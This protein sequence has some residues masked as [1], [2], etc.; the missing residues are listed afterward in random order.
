MRRWQGWLIGLAVLVMA[1]GL[2]VGHNR[3]LPEIPLSL[4]TTLPKPTR[5]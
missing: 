2:M 3:P 1:L 5:W 4:I